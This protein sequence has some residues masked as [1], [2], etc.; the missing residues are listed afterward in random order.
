MYLSL[1]IPE[2]SSPERASQGSLVVWLPSP[3]LSQ[4]PLLIRSQ[5]AGWDKEPGNHTHP[6]GEGGLEEASHR[7]R[8]W[9]RGHSWLRQKL[10]IRP[11][12]EPP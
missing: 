1:N 9:S 4:L 2:S 12:A 3:G 10:G 11:L 7:H 6:F 5:P 8:T